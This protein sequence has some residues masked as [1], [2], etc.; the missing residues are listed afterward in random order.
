MLQSARLL[1][2]MISRSLIDD[3][4]TLKHAWNSCCHASNLVDILFHSDTLLQE[5]A[6][7]AWMSMMWLS[8]TIS[9]KVGHSL[10]VL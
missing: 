8:R 1:D 7:A 10:V 5:K 3:E 2:E 6:E 9:N 4:D